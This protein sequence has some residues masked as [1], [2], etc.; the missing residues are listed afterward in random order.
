MH[1]LP[2]PHILQAAEAQK[3]VKAVAEA[4]GA[5]AEAQRQLNL[6]QVRTTSCVNAE[7]LDAMHTC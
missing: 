4:V 7:R 2:L 6:A 5:M 1:C 3:K